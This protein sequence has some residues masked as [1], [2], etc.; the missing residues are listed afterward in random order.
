MGRDDADIPSLQ[1]DQ[2]HLSGGLSREGQHL[3]SQTNKTQRVITCFV[4]REFLRFRC[5][6][7]DMNAVQQR[8]DNS[9]LGETDSQDGGLEFESDGG[10]LFGIVPDYQL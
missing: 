3:V 5:K 9:G 7:K 8:D 6:G 10:F 2:A 4:E 1:F